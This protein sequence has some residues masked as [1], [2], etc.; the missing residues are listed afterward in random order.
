MTARTPASDVAII[1][2]GPSG[3]S[4]ARLLALRGA[5]VRIFDAS[6]PREKPCGGGVT[7]RALELVG[8]AFDARSRASV[9]I[10]R[11]RFAAS[12]AEYGAPVPPPAT[13]D[14]DRPT[15]LIVTSRAHFD[16]ELLRAA[17]AAGAHHLP[18]RIREI[19]RRNGGFRLTGANGEQHHA[20]FV[21]GADGANSLVRRTLL[22]PF[23]RDQLSIATGFFAHGVTSNE[24]VIELTSSPPGYYWSFPRVDHLAIGVCAQA[25]AGISS[26]ELRAAA[27]R[28]ILESSLAPDAN[29]EPYAWPIPS[30]S[31]TDFRGL[32]VAG[33]GWALLGDAAGLVDPITREGIFFALQS[34]HFLADALSSPDR[35]D[36]A[37]RYHD[38]IHDV[39]ASELGEAARLKAAFF[40]PRFM[41]LLIRALARSAGI[42]AVMT[43][44]VAGQ[45]TYR[46]LKRRLVSTFEWKLAWELLR[47]KDRPI[48]TR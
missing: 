16:R 13:V 18:L 12:A 29:L 11:A 44:L 1:G 17:C 23:R 20:A 21:V 3:A 41:R 14:F 33:E 48:E 24:I 46:T 9:A 5:R 37:R 31:Q 45:Q 15:D 35:S 32:T 47:S 40:R 43:D 26:A 4:A 8:G 6:H 2:A 28:W 30:L 34:A 38:R 7:A 10:H 22:A 27:R 25:D 19:T 39:I 42:R 36:P